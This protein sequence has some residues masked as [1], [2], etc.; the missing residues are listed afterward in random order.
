GFVSL[1]AAGAGTV[2]TKPFLAKGGQLF[3]NVEASNGAVMA[4]I[5]HAETRQ[6]IAGYT[7]A[8]AT[9]VRG[10]HLRGQLQWANHS[11][12][13]PDQPVRVRFHL[14]QAKLCAFWVEPA[15][16]RD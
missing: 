9:P 16:D 14:Q 15:P 13:P 8:E 11:S 1:D 6:P 7:S 5:L 3:V 2:T 12:L 10:D 4:E